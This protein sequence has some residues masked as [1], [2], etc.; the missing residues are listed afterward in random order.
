LPEKYSYPSTA[1]DQAAELLPNWLL[2]TQSASNG[3]LS[4]VERLLDSVCDI[5][6][7]ADDG[8]TALHCAARAGQTAVLELLIRRGANVNV[9]NR[10][11]RYPLYEAIIGGHTDCL[12][13]LLEAKTDLAELFWAPY[14]LPADFPELVVQTGDYKLVEA[15]LTVAPTGRRLTVIVSLLKAAAKLSQTA[16]LH[17]LL[18]SAYTASDIGSQFVDRIKQKTLNY[19]VLNGHT[20]A[21]EYLL[22]LHQKKE[23]LP[24][25]L[26]LAAK[27]GHAEICKVLL[28]SSPAID[29]NDALYIAT[30][31]KQ[32]PVLDILMSHQDYEYDIDLRRPML[33][34]LW[35]DRLESLECLIRYSLRIAQPVTRWYNELSRVFSVKWLVQHGILDINDEGH[36]YPYGSR[37]SPKHMDNWRGTLLHLAAEHDDPR[38]AEYVFQHESYDPSILERECYWDDACWEDGVKTP[39]DVAQYRRPGTAIASLLIA[40][41]ATNHNIASQISRLTGQD[42]AQLPSSNSDSDHEMHDS[43]D[44]DTDI[45]TDTDS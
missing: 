1:I 4:Y 2:L 11:H 43:G 35:S 27:A 7:R 6:L 20:A 31:L 26:T 14:R 3:N 45:D 18:N 17:D 23:M 29:L 44:S 13:P 42:S 37:S 33:D 9:Q 5:D 36:K 39:L 12:Y 28:I 38:L 21:A 22:P 34:A 15:I 24:R 10:K 25:L 30:M 16:M 8:S 19:A 32:L 40:H 41:G